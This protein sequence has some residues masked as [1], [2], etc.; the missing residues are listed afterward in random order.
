MACNSSAQTFTIEMRRPKL[1]TVTAF[2][3]KASPQERGLR[4]DAGRKADSA[5]RR[6]PVARTG[7]NIKVNCQ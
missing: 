1:K 6:R 7:K 2:D 5:I 4:A 3:I